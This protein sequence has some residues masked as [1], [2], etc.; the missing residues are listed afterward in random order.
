MAIREYRKKISPGIFKTFYAVQ[1]EAVNE[2][3]GKRIQRK[4]KGISSLP[5]AK[6]LEHDLWI[7][8]KKSCSEKFHFRTWGELVI[9]YLADV[10]KN[11][12]SECNPE[13]YSPQTLEKKKYRLIHL[14][15]WQGLSFKLITPRLVRE[16]LDEFEKSGKHSKA[17]TAEIQ[18][19]VKAAFTFALDCGA[20][21]HHPLQRLKRRS[22]GAVRPKKR[23]TH[24]E[25]NIFIH[26]AWKRNHPYF[27]R[28]LLPL[29]TGMRRSEVAGL[30]WSDFDLKRGQIRLERQEI[31]KEGIV[32]NLKD[33]EARMPP[34]PKKFLPLFKKAKKMAKSDN[35]IEATDCEWKMGHQSK[36]TRE[37]CQEIGVTEVTYHQLRASFITNGLLEGVSTSVMK[38]IVG[39]SRLSTTDGYFRASGA[40]LLGKTDNLGVDLPSDDAKK[41]VVNLRLVDD[42]LQNPS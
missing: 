19:E 41:K 37:F 6:R 11:V 13:G 1:V 42:P 17:N 39:H 31:P 35:V 3:T 24:E 29:I 20:I 5:K 32:P 38:E 23:L 16:T 34:I 8:C 36:V 2:N 4:R 18:K 33:K 10:E 22:S 30:R 21:S 14:K 25:V 12:R 15:D 7:E 40:D 26:E 27:L 28:W 9:A